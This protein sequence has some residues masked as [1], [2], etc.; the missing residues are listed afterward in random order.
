MFF[1]ARMRK[2]V[3]FSI[4]AVLLASATAVHAVPTGSFAGVG[5]DPVSRILSRLAFA[6]TVGEFAPGSWLAASSPLPGSLLGDVDCRS[7]GEWSDC[8]GPHL[9][10]GELYSSLEAPH[11]FQFEVAAESSQVAVS[12]AAGHG[13]GPAVVL[14]EPKTYAM[15][16]AG[17]ALMGFVARR[18]QGNDQ[19]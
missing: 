10:M 12:L 19:A 8:L 16:L 9:A 14:S 15:L 2:P 5:I 13:K 17:L 6:G 11:G 1:K 18:R 7:R 4:A 3:L